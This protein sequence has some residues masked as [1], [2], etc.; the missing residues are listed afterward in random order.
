MRR[1]HAPDTRTAGFTIIEILIAIGITA[2]GFAAIFSM[3]IGSMQGNISARETAA[4]VNLAER[5][6]ESL[7]WEAYA[8][9]GQTLVAGSRISE[10]LARWRSLTPDP[11]DHNGEADQRLSR[12]CVH[13]RLDRLAVGYP[14]ALNGRVRVIWARASLDPSELD[15]VC[16]DGLAD[17]LDVDLNRFYSI[18]VPVTL[19]A[20]NEGA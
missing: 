8:W 11:V 17:G 6:A 10:P 9:D 13:Y 4:A 14:G 16:P 20:N 2:F 12:F 5:Y 19:R 1:R 3:Q 15:D 7:R 18:S